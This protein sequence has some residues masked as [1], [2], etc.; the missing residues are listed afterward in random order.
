MTSVTDVYLDLLETYWRSAPAKTFMGEKLTR[1]AGSP[2]DQLTPTGVD[3]PYWEVVRQMPA[4]TGS[5]GELNRRLAPCFYAPDCMVG[6]ETLV[7]TYAWAI[8]T[9]GDIAWLAEELD[10]RGVVEVGAGAGYWAWQL[11]QAGVDVA[12][13]DPHGTVGNQYVSAA[14][15]YHPVQ[16]GDATAAGKH[17]DWALMM[18]WP[19]YDNPWAAEALSCY[20]GDTLVYAGEGP[21]GACADDVFFA[22]LEEKWEYVGSSPRH[23]T[24]QGIHCDLQIFRRG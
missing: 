1:I 21:G 14:K 16:P 10:G 9:P 6:R 23:V 4:A 22:I 2:Q 3:N 17:P 7:S 8:P 13:Y 11:T 19:S 5:W 20:Q 15:P 18:S 24:F 12:A